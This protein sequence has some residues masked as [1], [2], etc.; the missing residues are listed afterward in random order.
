MH[1]TMGINIF[2]FISMLITGFCGA[3]FEIRYKKR[4]KIHLIIFILFFYL[5]VISRIGHAYDY[6]DFGYYIEY[7]MDDNDVYFE[8]G[9]VL[10]TQLIKICLGYSPLYLVSTIFFLSLTAACIVEWELNRQLRLYNND[11]TKNTNYLITFLSIWSVYYGMSTCA[12]GLRS[13]LASTI[14]L[15]SMVLALNRKWIPSLLVLLFTAFIHIQAVIFLPGILLLFIVKSVPKKILIY[16]F[17]ANIIVGVLIG[18]FKLFDFT[19]LE[20]IFNVMDSHRDA[21]HYEGYLS[22][23]ETK[24][25]STQW[26]T[27]QLVAF[28]LLFGNH[29]NKLYHRATIL[30]YFGLSVAAVMSASTIFLRFEGIYVP[31]FLFAFYYYLRDDSFGKLRRVLLLALFLPYYGIMLIRWLG[32]YI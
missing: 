16:W 15:I 27:K 30:Y 7:F 17:A 12:E 14:L 2:A 26:V 32:W 8:Y 19:I 23:D 10:I 18:L 22:S 20:L 4:Y 13:G 28:L 31:A 1:G 6:S 21:S 25:I 29:S 9:Y 24:F 11:G 5:S 3:C